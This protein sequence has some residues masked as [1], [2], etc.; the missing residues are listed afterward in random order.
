MQGLNKNR[1]LNNIG[2][3]NKNIVE[4]RFKVYLWNKNLPKD[5]YMKYNLKN[6]L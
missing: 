2:I 6:E 1:V 5:M 3:T 4:K